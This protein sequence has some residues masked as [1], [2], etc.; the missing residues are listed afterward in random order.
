MANKIR[1]KFSTELNN[2]IFHDT[3]S[4]INTLANY[5]NMLSDKIN[6]LIVEIEELKI[7]VKKDGEENG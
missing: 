5:C 7:E 6:E 2:G 4:D 1:I 3:R